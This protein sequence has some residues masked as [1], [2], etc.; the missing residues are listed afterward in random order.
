[1]KNTGINR[2]FDS[3]SQSNSFRIKEILLSSDIAMK[4]FDA[5]YNL[6]L[7][8]KNWATPYL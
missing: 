4:K 8:N 6:S 3:V 2:I 5:T 7:K 1:M